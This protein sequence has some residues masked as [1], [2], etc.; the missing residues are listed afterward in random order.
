MGSLLKKTNI[1]VI[2]CLC[3][4]LSAGTAESKSVVYG[5]V[6]SVIRTEVRQAKRIYKYKYKQAKKQ[7]NGF[8]SIKAD[9]NSLDMVIKKSD[10][11]NFY[12]SYDLHCNNSSNPLSYK[13]ENGVL[14]IKESKLKWPI[15]YIKKWDKIDIEEVYNKIYV[16]IPSGAD[17]KNCEMDTISGDLDIGN[18]LLENGEIITENGDLDINDSIIN[19]T[20]DIKTESGDVGIYN[21]DIKGKLGIRASSGDV[22]VKRSN[23]SGT[24]GIK[25]SSGDVDVENL[26]I[27]GNTYIETS[28]GDVEVKFNK[29]YIDKFGIAMVTKGGDMYIKKSYKGTKRKKG[30]G[31]EYTRNMNGNKKPLLNVLVTGCG[32]VELN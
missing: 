21:S 10:D 26:N 31:Y 18:V 7:V 30:D 19:K 22:D 25:T 27:S 17:L 1:M 12:V 3:T 6:G 4:F 2:L 23:I 16:Y 9:F 15:V 32:D 11:K 24:T 28:S 29:K 14:Y 8:S 20:L 5:N 13:V